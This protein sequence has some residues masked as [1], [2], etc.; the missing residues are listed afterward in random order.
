MCKSCILHPETPTVLGPGRLAEIME[1]LCQGKPHLC[2][3]PG[4]SG[5]RNELACRGARDVQLRLFTA[6]GLIREPTDEAM[7][8]VMKE[9][10]DGLNP[11]WPKENNEPGGDDGK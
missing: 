7:E 11:E 9:F 2:H 4:P 1:Y 3:S 10:Q 6:W 5:R 8:A